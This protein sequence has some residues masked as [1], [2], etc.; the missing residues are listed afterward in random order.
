[1]GDLALR[2]I[3]VNGDL[4][5][6][7]TC[8][9]VEMFNERLWTLLDDMQETVSE[10]D[11]VGI[12]APQVGVLRRACITSIWEEGVDETETPPTFVELVNP[13][14]TF[15]DG[16]QYD[17]EGCLS[18]P[19]VWGYVRR[20]NECVIEAVDRNGQPFVLELKGMAARCALHEVDHLDG[21]MFVEKVEEF[22][23]SEEDKK[24]IMHRRSRRR[25]AVKR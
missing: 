14:V 16:E 9:P 17:I 7:K 13:V 20:P 10:Q 2:K 22:A 21:I 4:S 24:R 5:L 18:V 6:K 23:D 15:V 8:R 19:D 11:G 3:F 1:V 12:A 25:K